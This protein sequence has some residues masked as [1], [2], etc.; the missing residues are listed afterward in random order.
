MTL[1]LSMVGLTLAVLIVVTI[2]LARRLRGIPAFRRWVNL[3]FPLSQI[4]IVS[5]LFSYMIN[6]NLP[7]WLFGLTAGMG[8]LCG[9]GDLFLFKAL[10]AAE[11]KEIAEE[12][13]R[14]LEEQIVVQEHYYDRLAE[15]VKE[16]QA[17]RENIIAELKEA[18]RLLQS[19]E[20]GEATQQLHHAAGL[21]D[22][23]R[24]HFCEHRIVDALVMIKE[25][26]CKEARVR[27]VFE[28]A[29][30]DSLP[31]PSVDLCA[32]F[33]NIIDNALNAC[34]KVEVENR[35]IEMK[36]RVVGGYLLVDAINSCSSDATSD[37]QQ[38]RNRSREAG[39][40]KHGWGLVILDGIA[41]RHDGRLEVKQQEG[42]FQT[43]IMLKIPLE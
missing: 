12:R 7:L 24:R 25:K 2:V 10:L 41:A 5:F 11:Q 42:V 13:V 27:T 14:L 37:L 36:S 39:L 31:F 17:I 8:V 38:K 9:M 6:Y 32:V 30:P 1:Q 35:F 3:L 18:E 4:A 34:K 23:S 29:I 28:L 40:S 33:S 15:D 26:A 19:E 43:T 21:L 16:A 20:L 22:D